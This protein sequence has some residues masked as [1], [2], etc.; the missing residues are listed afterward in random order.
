VS[1]VGVDYLVVGGGVCGAAVAWALARRGREVLLVEARAVASGA[2][3]GPGLRGVRANGRHAVELPLMPRALELWPALDEALGA[4]TGWHRTGHIMLF[5]RDTDAAGA[6]VS[7]KLQREA[8]V[9]TEVLDRARLYELEPEVSDLVTGA[10]YCPLDGV[11]DH[12]ATT[13][14]FVGAARSHGAEVRESSRARVLPARG[15]RV[16]TV[17][18]GNELSVRRSVVVC[19]NADAPDLLAP[20]GT[21]LPVFAVFPQVLLTEALA[22]PPVRHLIGHLHRPLALKTLPGGEV[23][24]TGG[25]LGRPDPQT[26]RGTIDDAEVAANLA[27]AAAVYPALRGAPVAT[28][29]AD[30]AEAVTADLLPIVDRVPGSIDAWVATGWS[31]HGF[32]IAP[33]VAELLTGWI[34]SDRRPALLEPFGAARFG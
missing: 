11:A 16:I 33:V 9:P 4:S 3:G 28:R 20:M 17:I 10:T 30:R 27:D 19:T 12:A 6:R 7:A 29:V 25:R 5:E 23:M 14:A 21:R 18:D 22:R 34:V 26:G 8:G 13:R 24:I 15:G 31:G 32:A 1:L 2:S